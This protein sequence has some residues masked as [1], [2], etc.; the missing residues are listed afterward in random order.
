MKVIVRVEVVRDDGTI[1]TREERVANEQSWV[2]GARRRLSRVEL[3]KD[4]DARVK[5]A[6]NATMGRS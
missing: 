6:L 5:A 4:I 2:R 1:L 3:R